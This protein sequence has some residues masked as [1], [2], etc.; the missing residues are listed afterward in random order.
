MRPARTSDMSCLPLTPRALYVRVVQGN[1][2]SYTRLVQMSHM[3]L[4]VNGFGHPKKDSLGQESE[5][6]KRRQLESCKGICH[7]D[8]RV[9]SH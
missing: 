7:R 8:F 2:I 1:L 4:K 5:T 3:D 6:Y 9:S